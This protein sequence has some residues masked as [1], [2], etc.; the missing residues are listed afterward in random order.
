M[1]HISLVLI[2]LFVTLMVRILLCQLLR[3]FEC[4]SNFCFAVLIL[5]NMGLEDGVHERHLLRASAAGYNAPLR[6]RLLCVH[7]IWLR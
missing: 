7:G 6:T 4:A 5:S 2:L 3:V 1:Q